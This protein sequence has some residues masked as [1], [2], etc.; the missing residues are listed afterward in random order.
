M[1]LRVQR[2]AV[3]V[4]G[5][6]VDIAYSNQREN[7]TSLTMTGGVGLQQWHQQNND[8]GSI[9]IK[10]IRFKYC[11]AWLGVWDCGCIN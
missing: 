2:D 3:S 9:I 7:L 4:K 10:Y 11:C 6:V 8:S 1:N 5:D